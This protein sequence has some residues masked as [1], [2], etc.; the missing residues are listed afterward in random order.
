MNKNLR[1][2]EN[3]YTYVKGKYIL[4]KALFCWMSVFSLKFISHVACFIFFMVY[5]TQFWQ[6][7]YVTIFSYLHLWGDADKSLARP[8]RKHATVTKLGIYWTFSPRSSIHFLARCSNFCK[9]LKKK[10]SLSVQPG[11]RG[12]NDLLF[13]R[14]MA[15][16][17]LFFSVQ[18]IGGSPTGPDLE[19]S[20][21]D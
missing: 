9:P 7:L 4:G 1:F 10:F 21:G 6:L 3:R 17:H 13:G 11:L 14:K 15:S 18:G 19:N 8:G 20:V 12:N 16:F 5:C 2:P